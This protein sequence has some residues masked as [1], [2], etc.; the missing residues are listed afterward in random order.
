VRFVDA[1]GLHLRDHAH[2]SCGRV[3]RSDAGIARTD[4]RRLRAPDAERPRVG[5]PAVPVS[6]PGR[7][8]LLRHR[9]RRR[10]RSRRLPHCRGARRP[11]LR[12]VERPSSQRP[13]WGAAGRPLPGL[14]SRLAALVLRHRSRSGRLS[15]RRHCLRRLRRC[16]SRPARSPSRSR[17]RALARRG[18]LLV[19]GRMGAVRDRAVRDV[20]VRSCSWLVRG[21]QIG[22]PRERPGRYAGT[23]RGAIS[24]TSRLYRRRSKAGRCARKASRRA[25]TGLAV[26]RFARNA[27][28]S[29]DASDGAAT[30]GPDH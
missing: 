13:G 1:R 2:D 9:P 3:A 12:G 23:A 20:D 11:A 28:T 30:A 18:F 7:M 21:R 8:S 26:D 10:R 6:S 15:S 27:D 24:A 5:G 16:L 22:P 14:A 25:T 17:G 4:R 29:R 19:G